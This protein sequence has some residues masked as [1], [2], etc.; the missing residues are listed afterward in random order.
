MPTKLHSPR[1]SRPRGSAP[2]SE[3]EERD[4]LASAVCTP[5]PQLPTLRPAANAWLAGPCGARLSLNPTAAPCTVPA[6]ALAAPS[7]PAAHASRR[8]HLCAERGPCRLTW[9][10]RL[11]PDRHNLRE[12]ASAG[13][14]RPCIVPTAPP[15]PCVVNPKFEAMHSARIPAADPEPHFVV[16]ASSRTQRRVCCYSGL[17]EQ[18]RWA[19][20]AFF[21]SNMHLYFASSPYTTPL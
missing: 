8:S 16:A 11:L 13:A 2:A 5:K 21:S 1:A 17:M 15:E 19:C 18:L 12:A 20:L 3:D 4:N 9:S 14:R 7:L 6:H 10:R